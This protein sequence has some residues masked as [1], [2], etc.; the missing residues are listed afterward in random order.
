MGVVHR[1]WPMTDVSVISAL[2]SAM[3]ARPVFVADGHHRYETACKYRDHVHQSGLLSKDHPANFVLM[4]LVAMEDPGM[5]I[6]P[7]HRLLVGLPGRSNALAIAGRLGLSDHVVDAAR[8][9][10]AEALGDKFLRSADCDQSS[11]NSE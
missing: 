8:A 9:L 6:L 4:H 10:V 1:L 3:A 2:A 11:P 7:S 5:I